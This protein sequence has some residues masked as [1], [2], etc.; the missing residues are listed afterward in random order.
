MGLK[1]GQACTQRTRTYRMAKQPLR[2][3]PSPMP[4]SQHE[5]SQVSALPQTMT[6]IRKRG[7]SAETNRSRKVALYLGA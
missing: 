4:N 1:V 2:P 7:F 6:M 5:P 3:A